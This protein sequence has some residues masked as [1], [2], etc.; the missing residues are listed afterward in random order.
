MTKDYSISTRHGLLDER[1]KKTWIPSPLQSSD[2][3][4][5]HYRQAYSRKMEEEELLYYKGPIYEKSLCDQNLIYWEALSFNF[6]T[7]NAPV[8][9]MAR[10]VLILMRAN[11]FRGPLE[12]VGPEN[13]DFFGPRNG[14]ERSEYHLGLKMLRFSCK[15]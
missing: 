11:P 3:C 9:Y 4:T 2:L 12:G 10:D 5:I 15:S 1:S 6:L 13:I 7:I 14:N 8:V